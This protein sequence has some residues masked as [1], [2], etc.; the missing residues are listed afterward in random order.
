MDLIV[1][2]NHNVDESILFNLFVLPQVTHNQENVLD[3]QWLEGGESPPEDL[4]S[5]SRNLAF[6]LRRLVDERDE[7]L[8]VRKI[9]Q[10]EREREITWIWIGHRVCIPDADWLARRPLI[11]TGKRW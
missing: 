11:L 10:R 2:K 3:L 1:K 7:Q 6:H 8:E 5:F 4:D 9:K